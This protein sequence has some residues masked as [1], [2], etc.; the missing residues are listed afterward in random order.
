MTGL[1]ESACTVRVKNNL[2]ML[3]K[4]HL[5][6]IMGLRLRCFPQQASGL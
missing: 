1:R 5:W 6:D 2:L 3:G 4:E